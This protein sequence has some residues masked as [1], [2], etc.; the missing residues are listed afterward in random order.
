VAKVATSLFT[1]NAF[2]LNRS[3]HPVIPTAL[4]AGEV[5]P[6][7]GLAGEFFSQDKV[8]VTR[9]RMASPGH[10]DQFVSTAQAARLLGWHLGEVV[11]MGFYLNSQ[12][13]SARPYLE[14]KM[15]LTGLV[16]FNN[17]VVVDAVDRYPTFYL[18]TPALAKAVDQ[19]PQDFLYGLK[20]VDGAAGVPAVEREIITEL[21]RGT[22]YTF[23]VT[24]VVK[25]QVN[26]SIEPETT[27]LGCRRSSNPA[28]QRGCVQVIQH[29]DVQVIPQF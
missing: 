28:V 27:A 10:Q 4:A 6:I 12:A 23:H 29:P 8:T 3:G 24:S 14:L 17:E 9:G 16:I 5:G 21:P 25:D 22:G 18:F 1:L 13:L 2:D 7:A 26:Q 19:G 11:P 20:L 15:K